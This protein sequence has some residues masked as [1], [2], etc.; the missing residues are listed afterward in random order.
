MVNKNNYYEQ[1]FAHILNK[2]CGFC[3]GLYANLSEEKDGIC[4]KCKTNKSKDLLNNTNDNLIKLYSERKTNIVNDIK[5]LLEEC[6]KAM[7]TEN[8]VICVINIYKILYFNPF[9]MI[10]NPKFLTTVIQKI[11]EVM[12]ERDIFLLVIKKNISYKLVYKFMNDII[13]YIKTTNINIDQINI[14]DNTKYEEFITE[15]VNFIEGYYDN[16]IK[17]QNKKNNNSE[18]FIDNIDLI[19]YCSIILEV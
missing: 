9:V 1:K 3:D 6:T 4:N 19:N 10:T 18:Q 7:G 13:D 15:F 17:K 5:I 11:I 12:N 2:F 16:I 14:N 8:K